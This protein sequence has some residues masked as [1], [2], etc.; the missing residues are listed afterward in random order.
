MEAT[1]TLTALQPDSRY[2]N[3]RA[4]FLGNLKTDAQVSENPRLHDSAQFMPKLSFQLEGSTFL[5]Y[6]WTLA[7]CAEMFVDTGVT[8]YERQQAGCC[9][10]D[11]GLKAY[12]ARAQI[13]R[14]YF[15]VS[16]ENLF[17]ASLALRLGKETIWSE[18]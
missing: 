1:K 18:K 17:A 4:L 9:L 14:E 11:L 12:E 16:S 10:V 15:Y 3:S 7:T 5:W 8:I 6:P 13:E 2:L